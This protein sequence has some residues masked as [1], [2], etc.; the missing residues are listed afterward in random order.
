M[1]NTIKYNPDLYTNPPKTAIPGA[2]IDYREMDLVVGDL[3]TTQILAIGIL[4]AGHRLLN[5]ELESADLDSHT[6]PT[7]TITVGLL[8]HY[9]NRPDATVEPGWNAHNITPGIPAQVGSASGATTPA[10]ADGDGGSTVVLATGSDIITAS[11]IGQGGGRAG[12]TLV[13]TP[14]ISLGVS[15]LDRIIGIQFAA[16]A[17]TAQAGKIAIKAYI[18]EP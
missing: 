13:L 14:T 2:R 7:I 16:A 10:E 4:P 15:K 12:M 9:Y 6:T 8:N 11:T 1:T 17:A 18:D 5:L 3:I